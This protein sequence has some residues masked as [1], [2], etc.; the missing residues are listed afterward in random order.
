MIE[1]IGLILA[2]LAVLGALVLGYSAWR[3]ARRK[4]DAT[5]EEPDQQA[6]GGGGPRPKK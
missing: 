5:T 1:T 3:A 6:R 4:E 2:I